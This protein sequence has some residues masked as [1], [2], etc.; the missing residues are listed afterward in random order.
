VDA[1]HPFAEDASREISSACEALGVHLC[2]YSRKE[3]LPEGAIT[4]ADLNEAVSRVIDMTSGGDV[5][6]LAIG[7]IDLKAVMPRI[8]ASGRGVLV[9]M[10]PTVESMRLAERAGL[11]PREIIA[12][13][14][15]GNADFNEALCRDRGVRAI[16]SRESG[17]RGG[18]A[19]KAEAA[20]RLG[21][22]LAL[23]SRP[24]EISGAARAY[25]AEGLLRWC[26]GLSV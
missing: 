24:E 15:A 7:T 20:R 1:T 11:Q 17:T 10:L 19:D 26:E 18:V 4:A 16:V 8:R 2:R 25:D 13:W 21:I 3:E 14:G 5:I 22:P 9:R 23:V 12:S 6:F